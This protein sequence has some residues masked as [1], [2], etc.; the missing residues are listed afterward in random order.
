MKRHTYIPKDVCPRKMTFE[1][2]EGIL[3][4]VEFEGGCNGN[5]QALG[6]LV[7]GMKVEE[8]IAR[9]RGIDCEGRGTSC[10]DQ[11]TRGL[12]EATRSG[13]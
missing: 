10:S 9:L 7:E 1:I 4:K 5:L 11:L 13:G 8:V 12:E 3:R 6:K 2:E